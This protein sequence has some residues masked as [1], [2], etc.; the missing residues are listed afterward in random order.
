MTS[1]LVARVQDWE[2]TMMPILEEEETRKEFDIHEYG[3]EL[4]RMFNEVGEVK[5]L[6][7]VCISFI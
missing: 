1:D 2:D 7:E 4:L 5:T 6:D 3:D